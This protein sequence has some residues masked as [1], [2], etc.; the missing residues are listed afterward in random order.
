M[1]TNI[2]FFEELRISDIS[3]ASGVRPFGRTVDNSR[4]GRFLSGVLYIWSG[5]V[6]FWGDS[7]RTVVV[8]DG[9]LVFLPKHK[10]YR[11]KYTSVSTT[12]VLVNFDLYDRNNDEVALFS[13]ITVIAKDDKTHKIARLA[14]NF[15]L[16]GVSKTV[17]AVLRKKELMYRLLGIVY[18]QKSSPLKEIE[19]SSQIAD[20]VL[21]LEQTYLENRQISEYAA[22]SHVSENTFRTLFKKQFGLSPLKYRNRLRVE[23]ARELLGEAGF[24]VAEAAYA[25]GFENVGY[26]CRCYRQIF[27]QSPGDSKKENRF[28][29]L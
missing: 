17:E 28:E 5:E 8:T 4:G 6:T 24:T 7:G 19:V 29:K 13:D 14:M 21:L 12:F 10:K 23:R 3:V 18:S 15:E 27:N 20:G 16:C 2:Q 25:S 11:M 1:N 26:F 22:A 9:E